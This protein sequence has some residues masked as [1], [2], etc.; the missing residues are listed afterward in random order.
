VTPG[1]GSQTSGMYS[2]WIT[3]QTNNEIVKKYSDLIDLDLFHYG[4]VAS[5]PEIT[6]TNIAQ[7]LLTALAF[8]SFNRL[9][10]KSNE[11]II[12][13]G[14]S[15]GEFSAACLAG[16]YSDETAMKL[17]SVR[18]KAMAEAAASNS[19]TGMSAVLGG[20]KAEI[21]KHIE[22]FDLVPANVNSS[23][24]IVASG[25]LTNLEKLSAN[26]PASTK[27]RKLDVA[28]AF[29]SQFMKSAESELEDE[30]AQVELTKPTCSF[31]SN[32]DGQTITESTQL[33][34]R[35]I[36]QITSPVRWDLC[37]AK[38]VELGVTGMLELAPAGVLTGIAK[39]EMPG[40]ELFAIK[41]PEDIDTAQA[42]INKHAK[43]NK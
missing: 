13:S 9:N 28:G 6:A 35:L 39:R 25:L 32:K 2:P 16:F 15:V 38:M 14:H 21:I 11:N 42:F 29:H 26:P 30:F 41:S 27:V 23:G 7:P 22:Q 33:K 20:D 8:M 3:D 10:I 1:Q 19:A 12:Y 31:I 36:S 24:Q 18:G 40:V 37:Q 34:S 4:T 17:V 43:I 5:Q